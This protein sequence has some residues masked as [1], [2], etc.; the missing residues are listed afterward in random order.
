MEYFWEES[1]LPS[2]TQPDLCWRHRGS[3]PPTHINKGEDFQLM[4]NISSSVP[5]KNRENMV[6]IDWP[7]S[8]LSLHVFLSLFFHLSFVSLAPSFPSFSSLSSHTVDSLSFKKGKVDFVYVHTLPSLSTC[9]AARFDISEDGKTNVTLALSV[10]DC[11]FSSS[12]H[13]SEMLM[14]YRFVLGVT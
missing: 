10:M 7:L 9:P 1:L 11:V 8:V 4:K 5:A 2:L 13:T 6:K 3:E 12:A 14:P